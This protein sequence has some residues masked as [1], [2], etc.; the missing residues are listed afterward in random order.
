MSRESNFYETNDKRIPYKWAAPEV[1]N[2]SGATSQSDV[3][4][5]GVAM[6]EIC[7]KAEGEHLQ[8]SD[9]TDD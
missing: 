1:I 5:F 6:W 3:F 8:L 7:T 9:L 2:K 4:S